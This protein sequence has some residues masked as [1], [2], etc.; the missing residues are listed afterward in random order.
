LRQEK[1]GNPG[2]H[3]TGRCSWHV[4]KII[5]NWQQR[6]QHFFR[7][8]NQVS[9]QLDF[10]PPNFPANSTRNVIFQPT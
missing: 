4:Y 6:I 8:R 1:S 9:R 2:W 7:L 10:F 5:L 3:T